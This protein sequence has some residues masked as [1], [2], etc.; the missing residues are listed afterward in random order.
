METVP[1]AA[2]RIL[3]VDD[4]AAVVALL[5]GRLELQGYDVT[6]CTRAE[7]ALA[8]LRDRP[9]DVLLTDLRMPDVDGISLLRAGLEID[10]DLVGIVVTG[11]GSIESAVDAMKVGA[12]DFLEKP[13]RMAEVLPVLAR[14]VAVRRLRVENIQLRETL[15][16]LE[17]SPAVS[18]TLDFQR[19]LAEVL[20]AAIRQCDADEG[21]ILLPVREPYGLEVAAV[22]GA[23][24][25]GM[26][27]A[28]IPIDRGIAGFVA[29]S[30]EALALVGD[31][32]DDRFEPAVPRT[33]IRHSVS[34]PMV[35][36]GQLAGVLNVATTR[37][38]RPFTPGQIKAL[39]VLADIGASALENARLHRET[40]M[41]LEQLQ[42]LRA[43]DI[44]I[45]SSLDLHVTLDV[46]LDRVVTLGIDGATV[47]L[48]DAGTQ[49]YRPVASRGMHGGTL[50][51]TGIRAGEGPCGL[52][53]IRRRPV[54]SLESEA[55]P[56]NCPRCRLLQGEGF[57]WCLALPLVAKG[58]VNGVLEVVR[59]S[60]EELDVDRLEFLESL[61]GQA[62]IAVDN[63]ALFTDLNRSNQELAMAYESTLEGWSR[64]LDLRDHETEGH[65]QRV[66]AS[67]VR[68][69]EAYG[70]RAPEMVHI[71][72]GALLHDIG[73][74]G[75]PDAIL[76][77]NGP[78]TDEEW[79]IMRR[80]PE[81]ARDM[82]QPIPF[83]RPAIDI[84]YAHHERWD[85]SGYP[86]GLKGTDIP[87]AARLFALADVWDAL[88]L[89][90]PYRAG[91]PADEVRQFIREG[92]GVAFDPEIADLFLSMEW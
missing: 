22:R 77:K 92:R 13:F 10:P 88:R 84:P 41:R 63:A 12:F 48:F 40:T 57:A 53:V 28:R 79:T 20:D 49:T 45:S 24:R 55:A 87:I 2:G 23:G 73:K 44:A 74:L 50:E 72:R 64:A 83:L 61:A 76:H 9:I 27:G 71:R 7:D 60:G 54:S 78:L 67:T 5:T 43:I 25:A 65:S 52:S 46:L 35:V 38:R 69:A 8:V 14:A 31:V 17:M 16:I 89:D 82:L 90:R 91:K 59:R 3:V 1:A 36:G 66:T 75:I 80:H 42:A 21:S 33:D 32:H 15:A 81:Y 85:G 56:E 6:G 11:Q 39:G 26:V 70:I 37:Q 19:V 34:M 18:R 47:L 4:D 62:A 29:R 30:M 68:L 58:Q 86:R 51:H